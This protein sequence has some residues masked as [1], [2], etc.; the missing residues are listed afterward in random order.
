MLYR[1]GTHAIYI[2]CTCGYSEDHSI[3]CKH[4][5]AV[6]REGGVDFSNYYEMVTWYSISTYRNTYSYPMEPIRL[7]DFKDI[8]LYITDNEYGS[9]DPFTEPIKLKAKVPKLAQLRGRP[10]KTNSKDYRKQAQKTTTL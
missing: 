9:D 3:P 8:Q 5:I 10:K 2:I 1:F 4:A 6:L 7:E